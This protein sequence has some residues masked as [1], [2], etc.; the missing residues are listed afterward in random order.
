MFL[1]IQQ[2]NRC[3]MISIFPIGDFR[4]ILPGEM[5]VYE[6]VGAYSCKLI[7]WPLWLVGWMWISSPK[8]VYQ[9]EMPVKLTAFKDSS[10]KLRELHVP[11]GLAAK[12][13]SNLPAIS[14]FAQ[15][16]VR[17][18]ER[19]GVSMGC[20]A[21]VGKDPAGRDRN[22]IIPLESKIERYGMSLFSV[23]LVMCLCRAWM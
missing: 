6:I 9:L 23:L 5:L 22:L 3:R 4:H 19:C 10:R 14:S 16:W 15:P 17:T 20:G 12:P 21:S 8:F 11:Y 18:R 7:N 1:W 2:V 13:W